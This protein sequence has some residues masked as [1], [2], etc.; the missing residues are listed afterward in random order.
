MFVDF[1][2]YQRGNL[3]EPE[4]AFLESLV[5][6]S[7]YI[8]EQVIAKCEFAE[9]IIKTPFGIFASVL[10]AHCLYK[11]DFGRHP[12]SRS[13]AALD[14][15]QW[16]RGN[17]LAVLL[18]GDTWSKDT[19][20]VDGLNYRT[21]PDWSAFAMDWSDNLTWCE[22]Y[23][24]VLLCDKIVGQVSLMAGREEDS[25]A[26]ESSLLSLIKLYGL[27]EFDNR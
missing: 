5:P 1:D 12:A 3:S 11:S 2:K 21:Y 9:Q 6:L 7:Q 27:W 13:K 18:A 20:E 25:L 14:G 10:S 23:S 26:Y 19:L 15:S 17:N 24:D 8:Q 4:Q 22:D 16:V